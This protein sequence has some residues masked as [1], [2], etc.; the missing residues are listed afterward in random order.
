VQRRGIC[1]RS[2]VFAPI[3]SEKHFIQ[4]GGS[5]QQIYDRKFPESCKHICVV[6]DNS[7]LENISPTFN[8]IDPDKYMELRFREVARAS[9]HRESDPSHSAPAQIVNGLNRHQI[10]IA[11][12]PNSVGGVLHFVEGMR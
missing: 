2:C 12:N 4:I 10:A 7:E 6:A 1:G 9:S 5:T 3:E 8:A 11:N